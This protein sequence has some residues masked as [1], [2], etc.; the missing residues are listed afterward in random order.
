M[1]YQDDIHYILL[2][3]K[4]WPKIKFVRFFAICGQTDFSTEKP[5]IPTDP[6]EHKEFK[7]GLGSCCGRSVAELARSCQILCLVRL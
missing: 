4:F 7:S 2:K 1:T 6:E 5:G 3:K